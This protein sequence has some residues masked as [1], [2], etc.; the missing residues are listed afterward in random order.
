M[1]I[2]DISQN[3][4]LVLLSPPIS[5]LYVARGACGEENLSSV[6]WDVCRWIS[7]GLCL[8]TRLVTTGKHLK[9]LSFVALAVEI[10]AFTSHMSATTKD[11]ILAECNLGLTLIFLL[12]LLQVTW[13]AEPWRIWTSCWPC[14]MAAGSRTWCYLLPTSSSSTT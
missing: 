14:R 6:A 7:P 5:F 8:C 1:R 3:V 9:S 10:L 4:K 11:Q 12:L 2:G 13:W